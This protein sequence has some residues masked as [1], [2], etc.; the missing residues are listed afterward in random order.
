MSRLSLLCALTLGVMLL[1]SLLPTPFVRG[2]NLVEM[3]GTVPMDG[4][5]STS[6]NGTSGDIL[7]FS[8]TLQ[9]GG[10]VD[11]F[12]LSTTWYN[13]WKNLQAGTGEEF[14]YYVDGSYVN[15]GSKNDT[16]TLRASGVFYVVLD[17]TVNPDTGAVPGGP[18]T[19]SLIV[20]KNP[21]SGAFNTLGPVLGIAAIVALIVGIGI[22]VFVIRG[23]R[24]AAQ[25]S[26]VVPPQHF[27]PPPLVAARGC[28]ACGN[29]T[30][31]TFCEKCGTRMF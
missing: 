24:A 29:L 21:S 7:D 13:Q 22:A 2:E 30:G 4:W 20:S 8:L 27:T 6:F 31:G 17:N 18:V 25:R 1:T 11:V 12:L 14:Y 23:R 10:R 5:R 28:L 15:T 3:S 9:G 16:F 26:G 19:Y